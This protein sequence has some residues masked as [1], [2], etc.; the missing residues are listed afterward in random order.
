MRMYNGKYQSWKRN[1]RLMRQYG[2]SQAQYEAMVVSQ[3]GK[4]AICRETPDRPLVIDHC[5]AGGQV[6]GLLCHRC[7]VSI[8]LFGDNAATI[9]R[10]A[11][12]VAHHAEKL[13]SA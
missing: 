13:E 7:N 12:Y 4:C 9:F 3:D 6:R 11:M 8:G 10:A 2:I 1:W 5:H